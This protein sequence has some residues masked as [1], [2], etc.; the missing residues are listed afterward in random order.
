MKNLAYLSILICSVLL[1]CGCDQNPT[2]TPS[3]KTIKVG[4][5]APFSGSDLTSGQEGIKG[6]KTAMQLQPYLENGDRIELIELDDKN[7]P[8][9]TVQLLERLVFEDEV[10]AIITFSSS[11]PVLAMAEMADEF[12]TPILAAVATHP[13]ITKNNGF[14]NQLG[15]DDNF[16]GIVA[17]LFVRDDLMIDR[18]AVFNNPNSSYS[19]HLA[20]EFKKK[21]KSIGGEI[22]DS[23]SLNKHS[24]DFTDVMKRIYDHDPELI[25]L[26]ISARD[27]IRV[28]KEVRKL[29]WTPIMMGS[30]GL[31]AKMLIQHEDEIDLVDGMLTT[32]FF[33]HGM[34]LTPFGKRARDQYV[35]KYGEI[36]TAYAALGAEGYAILQNAMNRCSDPADQECINKE[37]RST[38]NFTGIIG[39]ITIGTDGKAQRPLCINSI[40][41]RRSKF[42]FKVY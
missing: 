39:K 28:V 7:E 3:G 22:T 30:D 16:Q 27:V 9:L 26:P 42:I 34:P 12:K 23:I 33:A 10:A 25:Y 29:D 8:A 36:K 15:F 38:K 13:D 18:V 14:I 4:I 1:M 40:K 19:S 2:S 37:I 24:L 41:N 5:I 20:H 11:D 21:F 32:D 6:I 31:I 17:A 35:D